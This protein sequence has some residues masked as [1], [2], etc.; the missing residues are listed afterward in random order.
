M[1][2]RPQACGGVAKG[3]VSGRRGCGS[4][5]ERTRLRAWQPAQHP[6][7]LPQS[8]RKTR[9]GGRSCGI[10]AHLPTTCT[11]ESSGTCTSASS[12]T[13]TSSP[14]AP[15]RS[16]GTASIACSRGQ[17]G[18]AAQWGPTR[19]A[20][21]R[22]LALALSAHIFAAVATICDRAPS[23]QRKTANDSQRTSQRSC[24]PWRG[25]SRLGLGSCPCSPGPATRVSLPRPWST[26]SG[27][28]TCFGGG[29]RATLWRARCAQQLQTRASERLSKP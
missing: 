7:L 12:L 26:R 4:E 3:G 24:R 11:F 19:A 5:S 29:T 23:N 27:L 25:R 21:A 2:P 8:S 10:A 28:G 16:D 1:C 15:A 22:G 17:P 9:A 6:P 14:T 13:S 20:E 18:Q